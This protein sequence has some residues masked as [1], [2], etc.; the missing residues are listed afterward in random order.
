MAITTSSNENIEK[1]FSAKAVRALA[2]SALKG[3]TVALEILRDS[4][5]ELRKWSWIPEVRELLEKGII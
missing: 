2:R 4:R 1:E 5:K 3:N